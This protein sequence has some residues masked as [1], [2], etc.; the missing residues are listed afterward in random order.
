MYGD[1][2]VDLATLDRHMPRNGVIQAY[3][4]A[5]ERDGIFIP[6]FRER[7]AG[8]YYFKGL[9]GLRFYAKMGREDAYRST[10]D[11]LLAL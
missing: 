9:D 3:L 1:S 7:L 5:A 10:R 4:D 11:F 2:L 6:H 8:A